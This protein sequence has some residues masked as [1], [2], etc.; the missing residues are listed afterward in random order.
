MLQSLAWYATDSLARNQL[1]MFSSLGEQ[2][3]LNDEERRG[4][5]MLSQPQWAQWAAFMADGSLPAEPPLPVMLQRLGSASYRLA[6]L[7]EDQGMPT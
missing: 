4:V 3:Q 7:A 1:R 2:L 5:L 6:L